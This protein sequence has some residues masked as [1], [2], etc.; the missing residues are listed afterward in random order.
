MNYGGIL[1]FTTHKYENKLTMEYP[2]NSLW[3]LFASFIFMFRFVLKCAF[4]LSF[5]SLTACYMSYTE[6]DY[7]HHKNQ[8][9]Q[10]ELTISSLSLGQ[11]ILVIN[12]AQL[13]NVSQVQLS[14]G[15]TSFTLPITETNTNTLKVVT[16]S[17]LSLKIG[18]LY[19]LIVSS[20]SASS[21]VS[22]TYDLTNVPAG[23]LAVGGNQLI[24]TSSGNVGIGVLTPGAALDIK[25]TGGLRLEGATSGYVGLQAPATASN[26]TWT[27]PISDGATG[28]VLS[29]NGSGTLLWSN[30][31]G[32]SGP[33]VTLGTNIFYNSGN[34]GIGTTSPG[35]RLDLTQSIVGNSGGATESINTTYSPTSDISAPLYGIK[36]TLNLNSANTI[37]GSNE[38]VGFYQDFI[39]GQTFSGSLANL[40]LARAKYTGSATGGTV[41]IL[42]A[43][44]VTVAGGGGSETLMSVFGVK[45]SITGSVNQGFGVYIGSVAGS[46][47]SFG[48]YQANSSNN[49]Y[50]A[51]KV[52]IGNPSP[53][54]LL[55]VGSAAVASGGAVANFQNADGTCTITPAASGSGIACTSDENL[56]ENF[57][58]VNGSYAIERIL[59]LQ[60]VTYN[61][62]TSN[63][64]NRRTG[65]KAQDV[66]K[67]AP[68]FVRK[69]DDG[70][71][72]VY[73][74]AFIPWI[75]ESI[76]MLYNQLLN[77]KNQ[78]ENHDRQIAS[79]AD[80]T[81]T[82]SLKTENFEL[83]AKVSTQSLEIQTLKQEN[84]EIK[85]RLDRLEKMLQEK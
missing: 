71:L 70:L 41:G 43:F 7:G 57:E 2:E 85:T 39:S 23:G 11:N 72:Q 44:D 38:V 51:G 45:T 76:K 15:T 47:N 60:A 58:N 8:S 12:G 64:E 32:G 84:T 54:R 29:T 66:Q 4:M 24:V 14:D 37:I 83:K 21:T 36:S 73:Y 10:A 46:I 63:P 81:D 40:T 79:K 49:N 78:L 52:G 17:P 1:F 69:N 5:L 50:F 9:S 42:T 3:S 35:A 22:F 48:L 30:S 20:S 19:T 6:E 62:K 33:W 77:L 55:H 75:T 56:K 59:K 31:T 27:L 53:S 28:Q 13:Q 26:V 65:Y 67:I 80:K 61:F 34:V 16:P 18:M 68:E 25:G 74:D 82:E